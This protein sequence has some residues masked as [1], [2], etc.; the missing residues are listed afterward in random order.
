MPDRNQV[1]VTKV[2]NDNYYRAYTDG[3]LQ[4]ILHPYQCMAKQVQIGRTNLRYIFNGGI[5]DILAVNNVTISNKWLTNF[6]Y[7]L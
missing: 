6:K 1:L 3:L 2:S 5:I 7:L 4:D